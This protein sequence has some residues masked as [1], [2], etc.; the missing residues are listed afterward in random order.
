MYNMKVSQAILY[1]K[2]TTLQNL[3]SDF[4]TDDMWLTILNSS[5]AFI[6]MYLSSKWSWYWAIQEDNNLTP[7][8]WKIFS[9]TYRI[10]KIRELV[11]VN[12]DKLEEAPISANMITSFAGDDESDKWFKRWSLSNQIVTKDDQASISVIYSRLPKMHEYVNINS[13]DLDMPEELL[14]A[15][16]PV[17]NWLLTPVHLEQWFSLSNAY[18]NQAKEILDM[19]AMATPTPVI[20]FTS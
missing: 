20:W 16:I 9:T 2:A 19:Y 1:A 5:L 3:S 15:L 18:L 14:F 11:D 13:D 12:W 17:M 4:A 10:Q 6:Y 7:S 8:S